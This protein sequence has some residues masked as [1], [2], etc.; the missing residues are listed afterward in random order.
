MT[1]RTG[2][3]SVITTLRAWAEAGTAEYTLGSETYY[4]DDHL[5]DILDRHSELVQRY[6][7]TVLTDYNDNAV[8]IYLNYVFPGDHWE[9]ATSGTA[10]W[11]VEDSTGKNI[12]TAQYT[13]NYNQGVITFSA[14]TSGSALYL[15]GRRYDVKRAASEVWRRKAANV[16]S[17]VTW[18][19]DNHRV[20]SGQ[21][22]QHY[23][24]M[25]VSYEK[26]ATAR[27]VRTRRVDVAK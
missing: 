13:V 23:L 7:M 9:E 2:M 26:E 15:T 22:Y 20:E 21:L 19:S 16:S 8:A 3:A 11:Q 18:S 4:T 6:P 14:D 25:A 12:G 10:V 1:A 24:G 17:R 5:E 27:F